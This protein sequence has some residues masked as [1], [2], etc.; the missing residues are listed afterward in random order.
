[1]PSENRRTLWLALGDAA[2]LLLLSIIGY[3]THYAGL[4]PFSLRWLSTF[5]PFCLGWA[6]AAVPMG[7][8][9][10]RIAQSWLDSFW[11][12]ALAAALAA[13]FATMLR[14]FWLNAAVQP[15]F[16]GVLASMGAL[17]MSLWRAAWGLLSNRV[18]T[19]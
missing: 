14:G 11:R 15:I 7:L 13:T 18:K 16:M 12:A 3:L 1:M 10:P 4:E 6:M 17:S 19:V 5:L 2:A 9:S 8:Y